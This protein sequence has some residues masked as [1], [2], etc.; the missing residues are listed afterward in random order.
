MKGAAA[1]VDRGLILCR[2]GA[3]SHSPARREVE[4]RDRFRGTNQI[5]SQNT[6][7]L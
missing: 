1:L 7:D 5:S 6:L 2:V 3:R 4:V